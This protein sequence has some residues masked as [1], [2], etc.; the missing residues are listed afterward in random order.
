MD[1]SMYGLCVCNR[2]NKRRE[3]K[4]WI[5]TVHPAIEDDMYPQQK[6]EDEEYEKRTLTNFYSMDRLYSIWH[7]LWLSFLAR[8]CTASFLHLLHELWTSSNPFLRCS[9]WFDLRA[10]NVHLVDKNEFDLWNCGTE[11][12]L[13]QHW[14]TKV[15]SFN[16]LFRVSPSF[17]KGTFDSSA[18]LPQRELNSTQ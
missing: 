12:S 6:R 3:Y 10:P 9:R 17:F 8:Y 5:D 1:V 2:C 14:K 4:V 7:V 15:R 13:F 16:C 18:F 11:T